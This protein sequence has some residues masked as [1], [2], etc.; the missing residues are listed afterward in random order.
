MNDSVDAGILPKS[1]FHIKLNLMKTSQK[2]LGL[3]LFAAIAVYATIV[4]AGDPVH[5][6]VIRLGV[7]GSATTYSA[8]TDAK[9]RFEFSS[10][11][12]GE[13]DLYCS[14]EQCMKLAIK[15]KGTGAQRTSATEFQIDLPNKGSL[16]TFAHDV[17]V[18]KNGSDNRSPNTN[19][20]TITKEWSATSPSLHVKISGYKEHHYI[21]HVTIVK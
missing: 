5:G 8:Q 3:F 12:D 11:P 1:F 18:G 6:V 7:A 14:Y 19:T 4:L 21:G 20:F 2:Y 15:T 17:G 13:Y 16:A 10:I 9:G